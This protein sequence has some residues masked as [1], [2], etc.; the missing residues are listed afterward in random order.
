MTVRVA[1]KDDFKYIDTLVD[2]Y[3]ESAKQRGTGIAERN[4][5]YLRKK[6]ET[7]DSV[8]AFDEDGELLGFSY[9][10]TFEDEKFVVNSGLIVRT[11]SR[12]GGTGKQIKHKIFELSRTKYPNAKIFSITTSLQVMKL[13]TELGYKPVTFSELTKSDDF[14]KGCKSCKNYAILTAN[15]RKMC[16]CTG[17][18][19]DNL[20]DKYSNQDKKEE[21]K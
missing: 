12:G 19:Y 5:D 20:N 15:E 4:P 18:V 9:I 1:N 8:I 17:L 7:E 13:N 6:M 2:W 3:R 21:G 10:E 14:W 11:D 16:L